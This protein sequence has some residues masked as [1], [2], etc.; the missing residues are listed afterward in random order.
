MPFCSTEFQDDWPDFGGIVGVWI[1]AVNN[2]VSIWR[3]G[4]FAWE[5]S[6]YLKILRHLFLFQAEI[7]T[8]IHPVLFHIA[9]LIY[10]ELVAEQF[11]DA[12]KRC[13][14]R[15]PHT[16]REL[17]MYSLSDRELFINYMNPT[18]ELLE[19]LHDVEPSTHLS[20]LLSDGPL[21][22]VRISP[23][24]TVLGQCEPSCYQ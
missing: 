16:A 17:T 8:W 14:S 11:L 23:E 1:M 9:W 10:C 7:A 5:L 24:W 3:G 21:V 6:Y 19:V 22:F 2:A 15:L 20:F 18:S 13:I 12:L 4:R